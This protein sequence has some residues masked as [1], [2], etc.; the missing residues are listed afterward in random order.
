M[1]EAWTT[2]ML[3]EFGLSPECMTATASV[4]PSGL[5]MEALM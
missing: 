2:E 5:S 3:S 4:E 1:A